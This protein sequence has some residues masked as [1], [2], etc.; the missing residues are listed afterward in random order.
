MKKYAFKFFKALFAVSVLFS[1]L[2]ADVDPLKILSEVEKNYSKIKSFSAKIVQKSAD[3]RIVFE[4]K[5]FYKKP[6]SKLVFTGP[7]DFSAKGLSSIVDENGV[8]TVDENG[9]VLVR[10]PSSNKMDFLEFIN[11][12]ITALGKATVEVE[13]VDSKNLNKATVLKLR[14]RMP[15][16]KEEVLDAYEMQEK[17]LSQLVEGKQMKAE[18]Y[19]TYQKYMKKNRTP[20]TQNPLAFWKKDV[21]VIVDAKRNLIKEVIFLDGKLAFKKTKFTYS[22]FGGKY[23]PV[24]IVSEE[25]GEKQITILSDIKFVPVSDK[26]FRYRQIER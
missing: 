2:K 13:P 12:D 26:V 10:T 15:E 11:E 9:V 23:F 5:I 8:V 14:I 21:D 24:K 1:F 17:F 20:S 19:Q 16:E 18:D 3:G 7:K 6:K 22:S 25:D 4:G